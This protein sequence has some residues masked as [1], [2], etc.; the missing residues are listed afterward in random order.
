MVAFCMS[1]SVF[2]QKKATNNSTDFKTIVEQNGNGNN[3]DEKKTEWIS[4]NKKTYEKWSGQK[5]DV[6]PSFVSSSES[7][8]NIVTQN[9]WVN[10]ENKDNWIKQHPEEYKKIIAELK[11]TNASS[12]ENNLNTKGASEKKLTSLEQNRKDQSEKWQARQNFIKSNKGKLSSDY[13]EI[14]YSDFQK[15]TPEKQKYLLENPSRFLILPQS[16][17]NR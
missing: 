11:P 6:T 13:E 17:S 8:T 4:K 12:S 2:S 9:P 5:I 1:S 16:I 15:L 14:N 3:Y 7:K 10:S